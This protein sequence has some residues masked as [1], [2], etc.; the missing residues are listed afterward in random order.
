MITL[1]LTHYSAVP[2]TNISFFTNVLIK[3][4]QLAYAW[5]WIQL[6]GRAWR[7]NRVAKE[8]MTEKTDCYRLSATLRRPQANSNKH[9]SK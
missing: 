1:N 4:F 3:K 7:R 9:I 2:D 6:R 5:S 8:V